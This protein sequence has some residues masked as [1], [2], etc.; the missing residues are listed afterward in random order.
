MI[1]Q[2]LILFFL[3]AALVLSSCSGPEKMTKDQWQQEMNQGTKERD[4]LRIE[5]ATLTKEIDSL[6]VLLA[7]LDK[8]ISSVNDETIAMAGGT[9]ANMHAFDI[10]LRGVETRV[11]DLSLLTRQ[12]LLKRKGE[13]EA[14]QTEKDS[15]AKQKLAAL[16]KYH[17]R[18]EAL[19]SKID[20]LRPTLAVTNSE[21]EDTYVVG[22]WSKNH[23][24]LWNI[25]KKK[26]I[27]ANAFLWPKIWQANRKKI[28]NPDKIYR[29]EKLMI[30][31]PGALTSKEKIALYQYWQQ[32]SHI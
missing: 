6:Q 12:D 17:D 23:D 9:K 21:G 13:I 27:Y 2:K 24:C 8:K 1:S 32:H 3:L 4:A 7:T 14:S 26:N 29:G 18:L 20:G 15:L 22:S 16:P 10:A 28:S 30:P 25:A 11:N 31:Q 5:L 19:Q